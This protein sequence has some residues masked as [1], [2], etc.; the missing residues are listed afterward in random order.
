MPTS[1]GPYPTTSPLMISYDFLRQRCS[2]QLRHRREDAQLT[3]KL[4]V[5]RS[6]RYAASGA[7]EGDFRGQPHPTTSI[8]HRTDCRQQRMPL[9]PRNIPTPQKELSGTSTQ[10]RCR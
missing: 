10:Y 9:T 1:I 2:L 6:Q 7:A 4:C 8:V 5:H 3:Y